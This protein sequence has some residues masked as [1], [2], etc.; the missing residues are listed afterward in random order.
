M[1]VSEEAGILHPATVHVHQPAR[2]VALG[3]GVLTLEHDA[4]ACALDVGP[5]V[6][7]GWLIGPNCHHLVESSLRWAKQFG[8]I[9]G[10][11]EQVI[12]FVKRVII[13]FAASFE[14][15]RL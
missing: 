4:A 9:G 10:P 14:L 8:I 15:L 2:R 1:V 5:D 11:H 13:M 7:L 6:G 3:G 12:Q